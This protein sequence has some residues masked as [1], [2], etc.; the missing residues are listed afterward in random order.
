N[1]VAARKPEESARGIPSG[2]I[3]GVEDIAG[4]AIYSASRAGDYVV[5]TTIPIDGGIVNAWIPS[6]FVDPSGH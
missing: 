6:D 2:R 3:G 5:G 1:K 4:G